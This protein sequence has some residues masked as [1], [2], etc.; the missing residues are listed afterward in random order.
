[1]CG[2]YTITGDAAR[3]GDYFGVDEIRAAPL[4]PSF[5]VAP[6]DSVYVVAQPQDSRQLGSARWGLLPFWA[7]DRGSGQIN[8][9]AETVASKPAFRESFRARRC[10]I[11]A[12]GFYEWEQVP[13]GK[14]PHYIT[15]R[16]GRPMG[17]A[18]IWSRWSDPLG[19]DRITTCAIITA[20]ANSIVAPFHDR[21]PVILPPERWSSWLDSSLN[22]EEALASMLVTPPTEHLKE[23]PVSTLVNS[24]ANNVP[25]LIRPLPAPGSP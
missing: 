24:V 4:P 15:L 14:L 17:F 13:E 25:E 3:Y 1:M 7:R 18:G 6:T 10:I 2:R 16:A 20:G 12:D 8:A 19:P 23:H 9:R 22:D 21:M 11:P 5:N